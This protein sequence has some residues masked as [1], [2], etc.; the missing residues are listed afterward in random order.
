MTDASALGGIADPR[1][2]LQRLDAMRADTE[3]RLA[4]LEQA[5][6]AVMTVEATASDPDGT[7][8]VTV[9]HNG[10]LK[11]LEI[12]ASVGRQGYRRLGPAILAALAAARE[13]LTEQMRPYQPR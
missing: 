12:N 13:Q 2:L 1:E 10:Y 9:G 8:T 11:S 5:R 6:A 4:Q 7:V 3:Q